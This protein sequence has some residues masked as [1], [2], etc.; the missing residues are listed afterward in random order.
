MAND[1]EFPWVK[2]MNVEP[3][4]IESNKLGFTH[5]PEPIHLNHNNDINA[6][7][8]YCLGEMS[9]SGVLVVALGESAREA[10][11][12]I[13]SGSIEYFA[14]ASGQLTTEASLSDE[15]L[16]RVTQAV[17]DKTSIEETVEVIIKN[18]EDTIVAKCMITSVLKPKKLS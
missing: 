10:F 8:L 2:M 12:V 18:A 7:V 6:S 1:F 14:R 3:T 5:T 15:Q 13:K 17:K 16:E 11:V 4:L 9:G